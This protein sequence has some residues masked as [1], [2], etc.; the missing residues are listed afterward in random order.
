[1]TQKRGDDHKGADKF[2]I[3]VELV[4]AIYNW[5]NPSEQP[6]GKLEKALVVLCGEY[7]DESNI[8]NSHRFIETKYVMVGGQPHVHKAGE[9]TSLMYNLVEFRKKHTELFAEFTQVMHIV[10]QPSGFLVVVVA[11]D[12]IVTMN[13]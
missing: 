5:W 6:L 7:A 3:T 9:Y 11:V 12:V 8:D 4:H 2:R 13:Q 1:M 10:Q